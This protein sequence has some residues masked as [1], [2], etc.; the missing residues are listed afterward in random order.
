[1]YNV[2]IEIVDGDI[3]EASED[4]ILHQ[5][6]CLGHMGAGL[7]LQIKEKYPKAFKDYVFKCKS[8]PPKDILGT[9]QFVF[10]E[11]DEKLVKV[12]GNVFGQ[13]NYGRGL[14]TDYQGLQM[15]LA[16]AGGFARNTK[17][18]TAIPFGMGCG[19]GG[20][21]WDKVD[22]FVRAY[23]VPKFVKYYRYNP[24]A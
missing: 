11:E 12:I 9:T 4:I 22:S 7:A 5:V 21:D 16:Q 17:R 10:I 20:G 24:E 19:L 1:M 8:N 15:A 14:Q 23:F 3:L 18:T 13:L 6:N 2:P